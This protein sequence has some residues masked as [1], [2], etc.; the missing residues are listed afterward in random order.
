MY[1]ALVASLLIGQFKMETIKKSSKHVENVRP[2]L[3]TV[4]SARV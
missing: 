4:D 3:I 1:P 2:Q